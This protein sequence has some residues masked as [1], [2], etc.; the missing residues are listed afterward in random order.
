MLRNVI[1]I[2]GSIII[3]F[4]GALIYGVFL[5]F[6]EVSLTQKMNE[7]NIKQINNASIYI[8]RRNYSLKL[9]SDTLEIKAYKVVFGRN[10]SS[11]KISKDDFITPTG[12]Y[13]ICKIDTHYIYYKKFSLNYPNLQDASEALRNKII[14]Q[15]E[16]KEIYKS[17]S[18]SGCSFGDTPLGSNISIHG[19]GEFNII[20]KNLPFV[21]NWTNGSIALSN[22]DIDE[23]YNVVKIG[24]KVIIR[25]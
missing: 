1:Y 3:F 25:N 14:T 4:A 12:N 7:K 15:K 8:D 5:N 9:F 6:R 23:L 11:N 2:I 24:T 21:F 20:F 16:F 22:E 19:I 17:L 18:E 10:S 13:I